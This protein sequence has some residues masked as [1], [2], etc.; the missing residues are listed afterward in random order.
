MSLYNIAICYLHV[1]MS[2]KMGS[3]ELIHS[4]ISLIWVK[5]EKYTFFK[6]KINVNQITRNSLNSYDLYVIGSELIRNSQ[7]NNFL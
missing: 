7:T 3:I 6:K 2:V 4:T 1:A 5:L